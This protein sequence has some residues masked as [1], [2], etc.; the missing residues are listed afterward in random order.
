M[1]CFVCKQTLC[2]S[3]GQIPLFKHT[4]NAGMLRNVTSHT[5]P[6]ASRARQLID[7]SG[8]NKRSCMPSHRQPLVT[9]STLR[10]RLYYVTL[11]YFGLLD[12]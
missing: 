11:R 10:N 3:E 8:A 7:G 1:P 2:L 5:A 4:S 6:G 9:P 12:I